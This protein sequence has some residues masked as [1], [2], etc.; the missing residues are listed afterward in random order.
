MYPAVR[1]ANLT[2]NKNILIPFHL[3]TVSFLFLV[4]FKEMVFS[5]ELLLSGGG[6]IVLFCFFAHRN[7]LDT[8]IR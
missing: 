1:K 2:L 4:I 6:G 8:E 3:T 7:H 5:S